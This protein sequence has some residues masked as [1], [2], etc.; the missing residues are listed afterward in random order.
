MLNRSRPV[1]SLVRAALVMAGLALLPVC[2]HAQVPGL[3]G[4][5]PENQAG[6]FTASALRSFNDLSSRLTEAW[7]TADAARVAQ[8]YSVGA[9]VA[10]R[11]GELVRSNEG[12]RRYLTGRIPAENDL[13]ISAADFISDGQII[14]A[15]GP[16]VVEGPGQTITTGVYSMTLRQEPGGWRIR[17]LVFSPALPLLDPPADA[18]TQ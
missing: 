4:G 17:S 2:A 10:F 14:S 13:R 12:V 5:G 8:L 18:P 7:R 15:T 6:A 16:F 1:S 9:A 11:P 3:E